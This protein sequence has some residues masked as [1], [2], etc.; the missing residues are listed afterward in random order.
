M[1]RRYSRTGVRRRGRGREDDAE[2]LPP[3]PTAAGAALRRDRP[4]SPPLCPAVARARQPQRACTMAHSAAAPEYF[5]V[6][7]TMSP[8]TAAR[9]TAVAARGW[10][11]A[12]TRARDTLV[13]ASPLGD[14][15]DSSMRPVKVGLSWNNVVAPRALPLNALSEHLKN[16]LV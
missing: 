4:I 12:R 14:Q 1:A 2:R 7:P 3:P 5:P 15:C 11:A 13:E 10:Q 8:A 9:T 16:M 6:V